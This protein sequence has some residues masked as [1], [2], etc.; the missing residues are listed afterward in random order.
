M[1]LEEDYIYMDQHNVI[2]DAVAVYSCLLSIYY[3]SKT[4]AKGCRS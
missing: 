1:V 3:Y 2:Y 4:E